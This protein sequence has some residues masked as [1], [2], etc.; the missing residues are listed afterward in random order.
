MLLSVEPRTG[1]SGESTEQLA[2]SARSSSQA[3]KP[4]TATEDAGEDIYSWV[5]LGSALAPQRCL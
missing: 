5:V 1:L 2:F 4:G 3:I